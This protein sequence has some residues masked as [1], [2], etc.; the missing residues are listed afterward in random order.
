MSCR[1][2]WIASS[3]GDESARK[4]DNADWHSST[5]GSDIVAGDLLTAASLVGLETMH[6]NKAQ[7]QRQWQWIDGNVLLVA[8]Y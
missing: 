5:V 1:H 6:A 8:R 7:R 4:F 2:V 3:V